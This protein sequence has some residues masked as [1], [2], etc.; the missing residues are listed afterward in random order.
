VFLTQYSWFATAATC[1]QADSFA[2]ACI[3]PST[4]LRPRRHACR[5]DAWQCRCNQVLMGN[6]YIKAGEE[7]AAMRGN[8]QKAVQCADSLG[9]RTQAGPGTPR[10]KQPHKPHSVKPQDAYAPVVEEACT[11]R[12]QHIGSSLQPAGSSLD[13]TPITS[14]STQWLLIS[15]WPHGAHSIA[16]GSTRERGPAACEKAV[17]KCVPDTQIR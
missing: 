12:D 3:D 11:T 13:D 16:R 17:H 1:R 2:S 10:P 7:R 9:R 8:G 4:D 6:T 15:C 5:A 14:H